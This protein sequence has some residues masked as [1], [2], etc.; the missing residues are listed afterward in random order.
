MLDFR[1]M[2][3]RLS[4]LGGGRLTRAGWHPP[5]FMQTFSAGVSENRQ[6]NERLKVLIAAYKTLGGF[7][8]VL[9]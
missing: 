4:T 1:F 3:Q 5:A 8:G 9:R 6:I 2:V 7:T